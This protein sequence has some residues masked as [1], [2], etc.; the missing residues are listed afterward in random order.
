MAD[1]PIVLVAAV[2]D[3]G[4]IGDD[5]RLIWRLKTD[6]RRFRSLT[7]GR[8]VL[9]GRKTFLSIGKPLPGRETIVLTR[10]PGFR[11]A[12]VRT[13][14][15]LDAALSLAQQVGAEMGADSVT[16][17]GGADVYRQV[18]PLA[19]RLELT[20]VHARPEGDALFP[21]WERSAFVAQAPESHPASAD[22]EHSF[23]FATFRRRG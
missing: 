15:D 12:G 23:A 11:P 14:A 1:L 17:A 8:P 20:F 21:D 5:N 9:M 10:D 3:N 2:A 13:A 7:L 4:V 19:D 22:D 18:L 6:L 16:V